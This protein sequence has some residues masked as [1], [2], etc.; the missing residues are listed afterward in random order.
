MNYFR[1]YVSR[2]SAEHSTCSAV[3]EKLPREEIITTM[4][5]N[6]MEWLIRRVQAE[7]LADDDLQF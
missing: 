3:H 6:N 4:H 1:E 7:G 5:D 2:A